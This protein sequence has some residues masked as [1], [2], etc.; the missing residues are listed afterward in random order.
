MHQRAGSP[1]AAQTGSLCSDISVIV[2]L[3]EWRL[4]AFLG[5][6]YARERGLLRLLIHLIEA[7]VRQFFLAGELGPQTRDPIVEPIF[8]GLFFCAI[9]RR[10]RP[11]APAI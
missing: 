3:F 8:F 4:G 5:E 10:V 1:L 11:R 6:I 9:T 2:K 7:L